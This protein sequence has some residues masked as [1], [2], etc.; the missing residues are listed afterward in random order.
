MRSKSL[1]RFVWVVAAG[2]AASAGWTARAPDLAG[3]D[4]ATGL[5]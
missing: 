1:H 4:R 3:L 5:R 2:G